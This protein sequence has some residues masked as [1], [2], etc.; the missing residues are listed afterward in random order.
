MQV[1]T[2]QLIKDK[3]VLL[4]LDIDVPVIDGKVA[5]DFRLKAGMPT[6][7]LCLEH[8]REVIVMG[9]IGRPSGAD[10]SLSVGP[11]YDW[12]GKELGKLGMFGVMGNKL[13]LLENLRFEKGEED[14]DLEY[15]KQL[16]SLG[17]FYVNEAFATH[18]PSASTTILPTL[19][20]HCA[21]LHFAKELETLKEVREAPRRPLV[22]IIG[23]VKVEDKLPAVIQMAKIADKVLVG[24]KIAHELSAA[25]T[26]PYDLPD[27]VYLANLR[28]DGKD[29][30]EETVQ[31]WAP[32]IS[33]AKM[34]LWNGP[35]GYIEDPKY[36][37]TERIA[38]LV[39]ESGAE[40]IVGGGDTVS[41]LDFLG[42]LPEFS[43]VS[44]GGGAM[45]EY[46]V[47]GTLPT[48]EVLG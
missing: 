10:P 38:Q 30:K 16:A 20:P 24:G 47:K 14:C 43:F 28:E 33:N 35:M 5:D 12:L 26:A 23:G 9:H 32:F 25:D 1:A 31:L 7:M 8:A 17:D 21:G 45:L 46:L 29:I 36:N 41:Y 4:R 37:Q 39:I 40:S 18:H 44:T 48:I 15:A 6:L 34:I 19:L 11:I 42:D 22:V 13:K 27:N 2:S 3:K